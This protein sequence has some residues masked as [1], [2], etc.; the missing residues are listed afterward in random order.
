MQKKTKDLKEILAQ[1]AQGIYKRLYQKKLEKTE[2]G[3]IIAIEVDSGDIFIGNS[4]IDAGLK[5]K[6]KYPNKTFY[7]KRVGYPAVHSLK[8]FVPVK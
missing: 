8:G 1:K 4:T 6:N 7:F 2:K 3:K 5:A